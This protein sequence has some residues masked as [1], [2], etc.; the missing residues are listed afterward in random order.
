[1]SC[2]EVMNVATKHC[3]DEYI[4]I[5][6]DKFWRLFITFNGWMMSLG[7]FAH[8]GNPHRF[9]I[10]SHVSQILGHWSSVIYSHPIAAMS[11]KMWH[12][13]CSYKSFLEGLVCSPVTRLRSCSFNEVTL[14]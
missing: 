13:L 1:M 3:I 5:L 7:E 12:W 14:L 10:P 2:H 6:K 4:C 8:L 11:V 9:L